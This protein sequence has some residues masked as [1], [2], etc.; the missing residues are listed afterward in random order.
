M[1]ILRKIFK[2]TLFFII[3]GMLGIVGLYVIAYFQ[4]NISL[5]TANSYYI[6]DINDNLI[7]MGSKNGT[8]VSLDEIDS[9]YLN[10]FHKPCS[11]R[12][13]LSHVQVSYE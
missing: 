3:L 10:Y 2:I 7:N 11:V 13:C 4:P 5:N 1:R 8:W 6:Y 12:P 9:N